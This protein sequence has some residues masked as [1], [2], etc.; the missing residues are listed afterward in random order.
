[1]PFFVT[2]PPPFTSV[3]S[4]GVRPAL[5][6]TPALDPAGPL[7]IWASVTVVPGGNPATLI[8]MFAVAD[9]T[10]PAASFVTVSAMVAV[11]E[12]LA[13]ALVMAGT[14]LA[15]ERGT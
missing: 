7:W 3:T 5:T 13:S 4:L 1:M 12:P 2:V 6:Y 11:P 14:S 15:G 8:W 9:V 10:V